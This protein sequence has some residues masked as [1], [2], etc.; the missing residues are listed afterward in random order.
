MWQ[1][2]GAAVQSRACQVG[3][4]V[5]SVSNAACVVGKSPLGLSMNS[6]DDMSTAGQAVT[7]DPA[8]ALA[9]LLLAAYAAHLRLG[10]R[11]ILRTP[12][13]PFSDPNPTGLIS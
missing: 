10:T 9:T 4:D 5:K 12:R 7:A 1:R 6:V 11:K 13:P 2:R 8:A 3:C